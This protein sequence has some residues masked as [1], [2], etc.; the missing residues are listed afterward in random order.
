VRS[1]LLVLQIFDKYFFKVKDRK[2]SKFELVSG[3]IPK[4]IGTKTERQIFRPLL[5]ICL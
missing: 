5:S 4:I 2:P 1:P 3:T